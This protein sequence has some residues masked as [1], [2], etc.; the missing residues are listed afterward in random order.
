MFEI[1][2]SNYW[3][4]ILKNLIKI[5]QGHTVTHAKQGPHSIISQNM[6]NASTKFE[7]VSFYEREKISTGK[8]DTTRK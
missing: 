8:A 6:A 3:F 7:I 1:L 4:L 2:E 5:H